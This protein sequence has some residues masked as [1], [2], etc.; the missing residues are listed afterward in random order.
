MGDSTYFDTQYWKEK[1]LNDF[2]V[3][4]SLETTRVQQP[5]PHPPP[6]LAVGE[7]ETCTWSRKPIILKQQFHSLYIYET[8]I[9]SHRQDL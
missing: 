7:E 6:L 8:Q 9:K 3:H 5:K 4:M 2:V 1:V